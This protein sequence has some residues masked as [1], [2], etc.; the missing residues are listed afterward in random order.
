MLSAATAAVNEPTP[1]PHRGK[2]PRRKSPG[3]P[4]GSP[5]KITT[6]LKEII[7]QALDKAGGV[8]YLHR[9]AHRHP[10]VFVS[11]LEKILPMQVSGAGAGGTH[12]V[13]RVMRV[14]VD[15]HSGSEPRV[16]DEHPRTIAN[17]TVTRKIAMVAATA[18][19][20]QASERPS[21]RDAKG[22]SSAA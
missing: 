1:T 5:N 13:E 6:E 17:D 3:R 22:I 11:L 9:I 18:P 14:I 4:K 15:P 8:N 7:L 21:D 2:R 16:I 12:V 19:D 10:K 20:G